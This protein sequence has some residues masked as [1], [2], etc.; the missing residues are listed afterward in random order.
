[1]LATR[2]ALANDDYDEANTHFRS[3]TDIRTANIEELRA[4][5]K[6]VSENLIA[7]VENYEYEETLYKQFCPMYGGGSHWI[8]DNEEIAN[9]Y[10]GDQMH[11]CGETIEAL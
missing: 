3:F 5:F 8:S 9:P 6:Q 4:A 2:E 7:A 10:Y 1:Y 11:N